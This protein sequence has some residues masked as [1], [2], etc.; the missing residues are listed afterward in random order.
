MT[1]KDYEQ[2]FH[3]TAF[4]RTSGSPEELKAAHYLQ[5]RLQKMGVS[6]TLEAFPV[7]MAEIE[8]A[9]LIC[10]G[11]S[12]PCTGYKLAGNAEIEAPLY[13]LTHDDPC[14][15]AACKGKIVLSERPFG[16]WFYQD[17]FQAG[18]VGFITYSGNVNFPDNDIDPKELRGFVADGNI[19]PGVHIHTRSAIELV[20]KNAKTAKIVLKQKT[21]PG[22]SHNIVV[23]LPGESEETVVFSAHYDS[24]PLSVGTWDNMSGCVGILAMCEYYLTHPHLRTLRFVWCGSEE[25]GLLGSK[26]YVQ[27]HEA[28]LG[29]YRMNINLDMIGS[30]MGV[31]TV[32]VAAEPRLASYLEYLACEYGRPLRVSQGPYPSDSTPF[33]DKNVPAMTWARDPLPIA[34]TLHNRYDTIQEMTMEHV[35]EDIDFILYF[36]D[37]MVNAKVFPVSKEIPEKLRGELDEYMNRKRPEKK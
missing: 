34:A 17:V 14:S 24:V 5:D 18:A 19:L 16:H 26:A 35:Q 22:E 15:L 3:D 25:S 36:A 10:D 9:E 21:W 33:A 1:L 20:A 7:E 8:E 37:R 27:Q 28:E 6:S 11:V 31:P 4:I 32:G 2:I 29:K 30:I 12:I 23:E 13:Y